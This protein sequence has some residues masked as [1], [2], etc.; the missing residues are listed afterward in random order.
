MPCIC[1]TLGSTALVPAS[2][3]LK[4]GPHNVINPLE[5]PSN[6][7]IVYGTVRNMINVAMLS[8]PLLSVYRGKERS[9]SEHYIHRV[10]GEW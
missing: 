4:Y 1:A 7:E 8:C 6:G 3:I 10:G 9:G 2:P 5:L